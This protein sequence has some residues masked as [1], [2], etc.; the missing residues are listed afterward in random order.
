MPKAESRVHRAGGLG[1]GTGP[2]TGVWSWR[3]A[4]RRESP[5]TAITVCSWRVSDPPPHLRGFRIR[6]RRITILGAA[7]EHVTDEGSNEKLGSQ[8]PPVRAAS[9]ANPEASCFDCAQREVGGGCWGGKGAGWE[10]KDS[11]G[12]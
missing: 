9:L 12:C 4:L 6:D 3:G 5:P 7:T 11:G 10:E 1:K 2:C 8:I